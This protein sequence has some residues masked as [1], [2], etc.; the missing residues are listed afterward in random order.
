MTLREHV[1]HEA[2]ALPPED[3]AFVVA[4]LERSLEPPTADDIPDAVGAT[5]PDAVSGDE[6][7]RELQRRSE[8]YRIGATTARPGADVL[9]DQRRK[10]AGEA[11][12]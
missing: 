3:R 12:K 11:A 2:L 9:A 5:S 4:A 10:Q 1:L 8:A 7:L 6:F